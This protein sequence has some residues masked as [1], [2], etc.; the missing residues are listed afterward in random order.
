MG[1]T[2]NKGTHLITRVAWDQDIIDL[3]RHQSPGTRVQACTSI[4]NQT[5]GGRGRVEE[6]E[7]TGP[8]VPNQNN[9]NPPMR[10]ISS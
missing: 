8:D 5:R 10:S 3:I 7:S 6:R 4:G 9:P 1:F 2:R